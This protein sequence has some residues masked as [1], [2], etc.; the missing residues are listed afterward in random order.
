MYPQIST[1]SMIGGDIQMATLTQEIFTLSVKHDTNT[2][3][4]LIRTEY[5]QMDNMIQTVYPL[6]ALHNPIAN[7]VHHEVVPPP[8][9][10]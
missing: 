9:L 10:L 8:N 7:A 5:T 6:S 3:S 1:A 2:P 4:V